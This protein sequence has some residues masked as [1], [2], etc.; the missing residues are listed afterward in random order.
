[1]RITA[2]TESE[3]GLDGGAMF[4]IIPR[5]LWERSNPPDERN[6]I[7]MAAR[8]LIVEMADR[9]VLIDVGMGTRYSDKDRVI[10]KLQH[11]RGTLR[12]QIRAHGYDPDAISDVVLTHLHFDHAGGLAEFDAEGVLR[13]TFAKATHWL[14]REN[15][16]WAHGPSPRD[17]GSYR[18]DDFSLLG[19]PGGSPLRIVDGP[20]ELFA[21]LS[22]IPLR[23]HTPGMQAVRITDGDLTVVYLADL[24][25]TIGHLPPVWVMGYDCFPL[26]SVREKQELLAEAARKGWVLAF[27]HD[28]E[29]AFARL[30]AHGERFVATER[31]NEIVR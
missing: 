27:E 9:L 30:E 24:V 2:I 13:P 31:F 10:Y 6:R 29:H 7:A 5:P 18:R 21:G 22:V 8:C 17:S 3:F 19:T 14:Q 26:T 15:F 11:P 25:P 28:P 23:G 1:M 12:D 16:V 20:T 4:G